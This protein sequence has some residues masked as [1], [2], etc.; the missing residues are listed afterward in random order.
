MTNKNLRDKKIV[1]SA[2]ADGIGWAITKTCLNNGAKVFLCDN[3]K[4]L[5]KKVYLH[6]L[7]KKRL[8][9]SFVDASNEKEVINFFQEIK[10]QFIKIDILINN[11]GIAGPTG[12]IEKLNS[13]EWEKTIQINLNSYFYFLKQSVPL[14]KKSNRGS[15]INISSTAGIFGFP[16]RSPYAASKWA[17]IG[18][19][20]TIAMELGK[21]NIRVNAVCP[22]SVSGP[23]MDKVIDAMARSTKIN[24]KFIRKNL[25]SMT[26]I[27]GFVSKSD[28]ANMRIFLM[29]KESKN[30]TGQV[31]PVDGNTERMS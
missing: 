4:K 29:G 22:G 11:I 24:K 19:T 30:I 2:A 12:E 7:F 14:I 13:K 16:L 23:R 28:I 20:K 6:P 18:L 27:K 5:L 3:N 31:F 25:E 15:I 1:I 9:A 17:I 26:S 8:F 10:K 21:Y